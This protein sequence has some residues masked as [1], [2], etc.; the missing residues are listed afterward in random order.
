MG[1]YNYIVG[2]L[3]GFFIFVLLL[4]P[5]GGA[6][7]IYGDDFVVIN[8][9]DYTETELENLDYDFDYDRLF[10]TPNFNTPTEYQSAS[11]TEDAIINN[12][13]NL[14]FTDEGLIYS[15]LDSD[16]SIVYN[17]TERDDGIIVPFNFNSFRG[18][19]IQFY[20][21]GDTPANDSLTA[22]EELCLNRV[23]PS[24]NQ[25]FLDL[26]NESVPNQACD[27]SVD[28]NVK[29]FIV[30]FTP[31]STQT[32]RPFIDVSGGTYD[33]E[34]GSLLGQQLTGPI[35]TFFDFM[36]ALTAIVGEVIT[37]FIAYVAFTV[38]VPGLLGT[39][40]RGYALILFSVFAI[41]EI[42]L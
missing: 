26:G 32:E 21:S 29:T 10:F 39:V 18:N 36:N 31:T 12:S 25:L 27:G 5:M 1:E 38:Q 3:F 34:T 37:M 2:G 9:Q 42:W 41:K 40:L 19:T 11:L 8:S 30:R 20:I 7:D 23:V 6:D 28:A 15:S 16:G 24:G 35:G 22:I 33:T 4:G 14:E 17:V 13:D